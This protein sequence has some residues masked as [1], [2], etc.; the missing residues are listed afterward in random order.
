MSV[1]RLKR[2]FEGFEVAIELSD[3]RLHHQVCMQPDSWKDTPEPNTLIEI[4]YPMSSQMMFPHGDGYCHDGVCRTFPEGVQRDHEARY[5][6]L[7]VR[8]SN[9]YFIRMT[10]GWVVDLRRVASVPTR[11][12]TRCGYFFLSSEVSVHDC[13]V[14]SMDICIL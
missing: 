7:P 3:D 11:S 13:T 12:D 9:L 4:C 2:S 1:R 8:P 5:V 10:D 14:V 6:R